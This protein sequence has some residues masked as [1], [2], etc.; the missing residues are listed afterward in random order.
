MT[1]IG[2]YNNGLFDGFSNLEGKLN[3]FLGKSSGLYVLLNDFGTGLI[4]FG[5]N[6]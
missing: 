2:R 6:P 4:S 3:S 1:S 5:L